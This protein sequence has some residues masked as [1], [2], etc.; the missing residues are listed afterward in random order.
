MQS[1][2]VCCPAWLLLF[3]MC[4]I[5]YIC[6]RCV[7]NSRPVHALQQILAQLIHGE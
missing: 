3:D 7:T 5:L 6:W 2:T 1:M 4:C